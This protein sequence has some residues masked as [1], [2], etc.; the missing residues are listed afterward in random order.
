MQTGNINY[1]YKN[2]L[3]KACFQHDM[4]YGKHKDLTRITQSDKVSRDKAFKIASNPKYDGYQIGLASMV[5]KFFDEKSTSFADKSAKGGS[6]TSMSNQQ[7]SD[8]LHK[9]IIRKF[10]KRKVY[11]SFKDMQL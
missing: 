4:A 11:S 7:L 5:Y 1:I 8:E 9:P 2:D 3:D 10:K 6:V